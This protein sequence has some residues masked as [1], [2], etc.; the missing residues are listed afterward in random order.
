[1]ANH[2]HIVENLLSLVSGV[3]NARGAVAASLARKRAFALGFTLLRAQ[4]PG[5]DVEA[6][7]T[8]ERRADELG[9]QLSWL[10]SYCSPE[11]APR[12]EDVVAA[13]EGL[14]SEQA[15]Q[16]PA[17][18][19][20]EERAKRLAAELEIDEAMAKAMVQRN[21]DRGRDDAQTLVDGLRTAREGIA[22]TIDSWV[23]A[24]T[25][26]FE[27]SAFD[28]FRLLDQAA[29]KLEDLALRKG[30][31]MER[32]LRPRLRQRLNADFRLLMK[33]CEQAEDLALRLEHEVE[34]EP[35]TDEPAR[36][37]AS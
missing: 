34:A 18:E 19:D 26:D 2:A 10:C 21:V 11:F 9:A 7:Q 4:Q 5:L 13:M 1:M 33:A 8:L 28:A 14:L 37:Y 22:R 31:A 32:T 17:P 27:L 15:E 24:E 12:G 30:A 35:G 6:P 29:T 36:R 16:P 3:E 20:I 23:A 25:A